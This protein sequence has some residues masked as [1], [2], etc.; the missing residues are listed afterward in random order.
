MTLERIQSK[1]DSITKEAE[2]IKNGYLPQEQ[3]DT[4][5]WVL[6]KWY[7]F[8]KVRLDELVNAPATEQLDY[9]KQDQLVPT[10]PTTPN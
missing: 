3:K 6:R 7:S 5:L 4:K 2:S 10:P 1:L 9:I 8:Y